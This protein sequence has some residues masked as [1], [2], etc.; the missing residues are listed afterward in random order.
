MMLPDVCTVLIDC[1]T[2]GEKKMQE[3]NYNDLN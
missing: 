2:I 1:K 3:H